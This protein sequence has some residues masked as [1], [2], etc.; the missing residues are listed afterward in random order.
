[1]AQPRPS[2]A[3][4]AAAI[5]PTIP[6][7]VTDAALPQPLGRAKLVTNDHPL[8]PPGQTLGRDRRAQDLDQPR[9]ALLG[10]AQ[11]GRRGRGPADQRAGCADRRGADQSPGPAGTGRGDQ[12]VAGG[13]VGEQ[14]GVG[15][16]IPGY[17]SANRIENSPDPVSLPV[18]GTLE[19]SIAI[20]GFGLELGE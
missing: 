15:G 20:F 5:G 17:E 9:A 12:A 16:S 18:R 3:S 6:S 14:D 10:T 8:P 19:T 1:M 4:G 2:P 7:D 11:A 13:L